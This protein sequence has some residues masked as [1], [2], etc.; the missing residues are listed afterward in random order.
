MTVRPFLGFSPCCGQEE[1]M[2]KLE[3]SKSLSNPE[4]TD[5]GKGLGVLEP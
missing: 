1:K 5:D 3:I 4:V 2:L